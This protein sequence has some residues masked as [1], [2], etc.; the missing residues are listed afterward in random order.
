MSPDVICWSMREGL[1][2][3]AE[4]LLRGGPGVR[5]VA[6]R[7]MPTREVEEFTLLLMD[8][9]DSSPAGARPGIN[10]KIGVMEALQLVGG[11]SDPTL[12]PRSFQ[13]FANKGVLRGAYGPRVEH[14]LPHLVERLRSDP[15][16]RQAVLQVWDGETDLIRHRPGTGDFPCT[17]NW[18]FRVRD[19]Q[20]H[21]TT[22]MRSND[23]YWGLPY[24]A[25]FMTQLQQTVA[26]LLGL[27]VGHYVH[28]ATSLHLYERDVEKVEE[29]VRCL[30][31]L[32]ERD[33]DDPGAT[34]AAWEAKRFGGIDGASSA[35][36]AQDRAW[37]LAY[38][39]ELNGAPWTASERAYA[40]VLRG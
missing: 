6:P 29:M 32:V 17:L 31:P 25:F 26:A 28:R 18:L 10:L 12:F 19:G 39:R 7:G 11:F 2:L 35:T 13:Q 8:P 24:D 3:T 5:Q 20:L 23:I 37:A 22:V 40:E 14:Q 16:T 33:A 34:T 27:E 4:R 36:E 15:D 38:G 9:R 30:G 21:M 1:L